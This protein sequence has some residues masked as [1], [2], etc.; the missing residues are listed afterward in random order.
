M[1][2][3]C[4]FFIHRIIGKRHMLLNVHGPEERP[5]RDLGALKTLVLGTKFHSAYQEEQP[6]AAKL[7]RRNRFFVH[8][9]FSPECLTPVDHKLGLSAQ[10]EEED[11]RCENDPIRSSD[12][13]VNRLHVIGDNA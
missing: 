1:I 7:A 9:L 8:V 12:V 10:S 13:T 5:S 11:G 4:A 2:H 6:L 3:Y